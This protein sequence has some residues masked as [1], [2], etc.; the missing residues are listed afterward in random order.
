MFMPVAIYFIVFSYF[1]LAGIIVAFKNYNYQKGLFLSPWN[2]I[3]NFTFFFRS[4]KAWLVTRNTIFYNLIFIIF[5]NLFSI[6]V[7][8][9]LSEIVSKMFK[10]I[11]QTMMFLPYFISWVTVAAFMYNFFGY[12]YGMLNSLLVK[13]GKTPIDIYANPT[14]WYFLLPFLYVWKSVGFGS[15]LYLSAIMGIE[16]ESYESA[17]LDG[18]NRYQKIIYITI[19]MLK[20][21]M[22]TLVL[23]SLGR[24]LRGEFDMFYQL[25]G[26]IG[27]LFDQTDIIDTMVFRTLMIV[28][29]FGIASASGFYQSVL[30]FLIITLVNG[31]VRH[32][33]K[34]YAL[35]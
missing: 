29:D 26:T 8:I 27:T 33:N 23:L 13:I 28:N 12:E 25:V 15:V 6:I 5:Y 30:C 18:A 4:G 32:I 31:T 3:D 14:F 21:T 10:K 16:Q 22:Y 17:S 19:P 34:D 20:P 9:C 24:I 1:P 7:A 35:Y 11:S 2:G